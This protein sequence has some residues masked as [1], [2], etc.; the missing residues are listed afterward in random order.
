MHDAE[1]DSFRAQVDCRAVLEQAG[2]LLDA[3]ESSKNAV[4]YRNGPA[5]IV[6]VTHD[7]RGWFDP[8]NDSRG[9]VISLAQHLWGGTIGHARKM[10]RPLSG[11]VPAMLPHQR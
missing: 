7:G 11:I 6:I 5:R 2:W 1:L 10:L 9:D 3:K 4:K 8:L